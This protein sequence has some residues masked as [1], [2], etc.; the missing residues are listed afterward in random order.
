MAH[1]DHA[2]MKTPLNTVPAAVSLYRSNRAL[3]NAAVSMANSINCQVRRRCLF[4]R[5]CAFA[6]P[7]WRI[8]K[9]QEKTACIDH[10]YCPPP[11]PHPATYTH[12]H[13]RTL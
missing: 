9:Q 10:F 3:A 1:V 8:G 13:T 11:H 2:L 7:V 4:W 12:T 5:L 6:A